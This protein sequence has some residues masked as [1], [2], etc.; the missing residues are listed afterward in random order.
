MS[1]T[2]SYLISTL[3]LLIVSLCICN[4]AY[5]QRTS[6]NGIDGKLDQ[7]L[8]V[9]P[10]ID[11][12]VTLTKRA[13]PMPDGCNGAYVY[14]E[15]GPNGELSGS[16]YV[17]PADH[18]LIIHDIS[19]VGES[20]LPDGAFV[21]GYLL[22]LRLTSRN[23]NNSD[24]RA[25]YF[26]PPIVVTADNKNGLLGGNDS[27]I[28]GLTI[29]SGRILCADVNGTNKTSIGVQTVYYA[30]HETILHGYLVSI[31]Q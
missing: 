31:S 30:P 5:A 18:V 14:V 22:R 16:Q 29:G 15:L 21:P 9:S 26:S 3:L 7:L 6:V 19:F 1:L 17:V 8:A 11:S 4:P 27:L 28:A 23:A 2:R 13:A 12:H 24:P 10:G 20:L 25:V